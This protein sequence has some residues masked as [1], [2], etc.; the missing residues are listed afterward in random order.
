MQM[1]PGVVF[2]S[3]YLAVP[4]FCFA[5]AELAECAETGE[6]RIRISRAVPVVAPSEHSP[7]D[8]GELTVENVE[9]TYMVSIPY[10][11]VI[12]GQKIQRVRTETRA[13]I[14]PIRRR[15]YKP[16]V[17]SGKPLV[18]QTYTACVPY[19]E[20]VPLAD[21]STVTVTRSRLETRTHMVDPDAPQPRL[22]P[23]MIANDYNVELTKCC[24][25]NGEEIS[26]A[27]KL[28]LLSTPTPVLLVRG[29]DSITPYFSGLLKA[30]SII[31]FDL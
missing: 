14:V 15:K 23:Q 21:G 11:E 13:R 10:T 4:Q 19:T 28:R 22:I 17:S 30:D 6:I 18:E 26:D 31:V 24:F 27:D 7:D 2:G 8:D 16:A 25:P 5:I 12:D 29:T 1:E 9:Q 3:P 20:Q